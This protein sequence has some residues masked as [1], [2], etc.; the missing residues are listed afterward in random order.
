MEVQGLVKIL[1]SNTS[2][3]AALP[4]SVPENGQG[5]GM[6][7]SILHMGDSGAGDRIKMQ[8]EAICVCERGA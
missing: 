7:A 4:L 8:G 1:E 3:P 6:L 2:P 5:R